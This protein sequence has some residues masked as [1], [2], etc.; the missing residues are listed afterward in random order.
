MRISLKWKMMLVFSIVTVVIWVATIGYTFP[1]VAGLLKQATL[2]GNADQAF[3]I[4]KRNVLIAGTGGTFFS[5]FVG[6]IMALVILKPMNNVVQAMAKASEGD[7]TSQ[8]TCGTKDELLLLACGFNELVENFKDYT[9]KIK[10]IGEEV[11]EM[12]TGLSLNVRESSQSTEQIAVTMQHVAMG[13]EDQSQSIRSTSAT[14]GDMSTG[15]HQIAANSRSVSQLSQ[16]T[17]EIAIQGGQAVDDSVS[18][19]N[20]ISETV[21]NSAQTVQLLGDRSVEIGQI[22]GTITDMAEQTNLLALNAAIEAARAGEQG[23]GFAVVAEE[24]RKLAEQSA[25]AA[26]QISELINQIQKETKQAVES[27]NRGTVEVDNGI[28]VVT[29]AGEAFAKI[30]T[31]IQNVAKQIEEVSIA[32]QAMADGGQEVVQLMGSIEG[33]AINTAGS[34]QEVAAAIEELSAN[35][36]EHQTMS[37]RLSNMSSELMDMVKGMKLE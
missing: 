10:D 3:R 22:V 17:T 37:N 13:M 16:A 30:V 11:A 34:T 27:M 26:Q 14:I 31:S 9:M 7:L 18:Q 21:N 15:I 1:T 35:Y 24:V 20:T 2:D 32:S 33:I 23:R 36:S 8:A 25:T 29:N 19:M 4:F 5:I 28:Q 6:Y 12:A